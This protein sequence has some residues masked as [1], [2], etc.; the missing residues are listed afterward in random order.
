MKCKNFKV[1]KQ[2]LN[3]GVSPLCTNCDGMTAVH[4]SIELD[5][6]EYLTYLFEGDATL[7]PDTTS[8]S[9]K[10]HKK[11]S[12]S[13]IPLSTE[14]FFSR[15]SGIKFVWDSLHS[16]DQKTIVEGYTPFHLAIIKANHIILRYI[17]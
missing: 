11:Q 8:K 3:K 5:R 14:E 6:L 1:F 12:S 2:L 16:L 4:Y 13:R 10:R 17:V 7:T 9:P 15:V